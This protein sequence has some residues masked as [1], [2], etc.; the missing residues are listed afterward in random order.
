MA[1]LT[2]KQ[3]LLKDNVYKWTKSVTIAEAYISILRGN[4]FV[5][6]VGRIYFAEKKLRQEEFSD[7]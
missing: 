5:L 4:G 1:R 2:I 6:I 3:I 7:A